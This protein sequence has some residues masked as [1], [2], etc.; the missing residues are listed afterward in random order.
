MA[1]LVLIIVLERPSSI[2]PRHPSITVLSTTICMSWQV[3][4]LTCPNDC[5][6][7][8]TG[9]RHRPSIFMLDMSSTNLVYVLAYL[10]RL[11]IRL[12]LPQARPVSRCNV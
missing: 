7:M 2:Q 3:V 8:V 10:E 11:K 5:P 9:M 6:H 1:F 12:L 4:P